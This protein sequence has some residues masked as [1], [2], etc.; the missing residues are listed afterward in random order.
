VKLNAKCLSGRPNRL[1]SASEGTSC[2]SGPVRGKRSDWRLISTAKDRAGSALP[3]KI[4]NTLFVI[5]HRAGIGVG[6][7]FEP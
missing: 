5:T 1:L 4:L 7:D 3:N 2:A 6:D